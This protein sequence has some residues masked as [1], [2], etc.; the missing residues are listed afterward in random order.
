MND[1]ERFKSVISF[2]KPDQW[3]LILTLGGFAV[4]KGGWAKLHREGLPPSVN[5]K[6]SWCRY[7]GQVMFDQAKDIGVGEREPKIETWVKDGYEYTRSET[8]SLTR[9]VADHETNYS[10]P[11][12]IEFE[13]SD[14]ASWERI[15]TFS[16]TGA[17]KEKLQE[18]V[19]QFKNRTRPLM[20]QCGGTWGSVRNLM[21]PER[22]LTVLYDDPD[23]VHEMIAYI[24]DSVERFIFPVI[25]KI[26]A[27]QFRHPKAVTAGNRDQ[28]STHRSRF[29][30]WSVVV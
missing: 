3:P 23:L 17:S 22:A 1:L 7:F 10:M 19:A 5:D 27:T 16:C 21:G 13:V 9:R 24:L 28:P 25:L 12:F 2:E 6:E 14:R 15:K 11:E 30:F 20:V 4:T 8:G 18:Q 29:G 26:A